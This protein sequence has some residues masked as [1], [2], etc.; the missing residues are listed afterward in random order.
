MQAVKAKAPA[1]R[2][3]RKAH[4]PG[5]IVAGGRLVRM[6]VDVPEGMSLDALIASLSEARARA[7]QPLDLSLR[8]SAGA[9]SCFMMLYRERG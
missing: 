1:R 7:A 2:R 3:S 6:T 5:S 4:A 8:E 9:G